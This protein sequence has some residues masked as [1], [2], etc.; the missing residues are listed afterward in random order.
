MLIKIKQLLLKNKEQIH[1]S[2]GNMNGDQKSTHFYKIE[3]DRI[4]LVD[5]L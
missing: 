1:G 2:S 4:I 5:R 3:G